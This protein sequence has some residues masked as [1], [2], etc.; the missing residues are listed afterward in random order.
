M[1]DIITPGGEIVTAGK[2]AIFHAVLL[3]LEQRVH[4]SVAFQQPLQ[5][6]SIHPDV[7]LRAR[8][9]AHQFHHHVLVI[10]RNEGSRLAEHLSKDLGQPQG[11][12]K[13][14]RTAQ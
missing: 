10:W 14:H 2:L 9:I 11:C 12:E 4:L 1:P 5:P 7:N 8:S 6:P 13:R 3:F